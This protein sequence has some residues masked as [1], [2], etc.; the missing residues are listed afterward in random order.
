MKGYS[1]YKSSGLLSFNEVPSH[2]KKDRIKYIGFMYGGL[3]G[4]S[5]D[6]FRRDEDDPSNKPFIP[7]TNICNN[8]YI[9][10]D[11]LKLVSITE[12]DNQN[13]VQKD[14][15]FFMMTSETQ[16]DVGKTSVLKEDLGE[17][18]LNTFCKGFRIIDKSVNPYFLNY[19]LYGGDG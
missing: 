7:F 18:Y 17:V 12:D 16:D 3:T 19:L 14:D 11:D 5:G 9:S 2:W 1:K 8:T 13:R 6:D 15:L 4:K 10:K